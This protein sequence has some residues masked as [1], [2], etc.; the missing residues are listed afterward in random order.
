MYKATG[1]A[2]SRNW[3]LGLI[4]AI[5]LIPVS[6][7]AQN[8]RTVTGTVVDETG[9]PLIGASVRVV[10][11]STGV[12]TDI[13][14]R[15]S[16][17]VPASA[18]QLLF[19]YVGYHNLTAGITSDVVDV[20]LH[21]DNE[22]LD[23]VV[24]IGYGTQKKNDLT[25]SVSSVGEKDFNQGLISSPEELINGKIAGVQITSNGGS[26]NGGSTIRIR[27]GASLNAS[28]DPLIVLD[29]VPME[30]GDGITGSGN[31]LSMINPNDIESM[32][33]LKDASSTAIYG[34]RASNG[35]I[36]INTKKGS[37][38]GIKVSFQ[39][40]NSL[41]NATR[42]NKMLSRSQL[43]EEVYA[44][45]NQDYISALGDADTDWND[46]IFRT[47]FSTDNN[48][49]LSGRFTNW[50]PFRVSLGATY[51]E[52]ILKNDNSQ[53]YTANINLTPSFFGD[54]LR[55][56]LSG[57]GSYSKNR[58]ANSGAIWNALAYDPTQ[59]VYGNFD[60]DGNPLLFT[61]GSPLMGGFHQVIDK[62][63]YPGQGAIA[64]P[65]AMLEDPDNP[66]DVYRIVSNLDVEYRLHF[67][68]E[69][70]L[71]AT[72]GVDWARGTSKYYLP[73]NSFEGFRDGGS[74]NEQG[75]QINL[76]QVLTLY[77]NYNKDFEA[78]KSTVDVTA[79]YDYQYWK[80][81]APGYDTFNAAGEYRSTSA[82]WDERHSLIS[83]Y[84]RINY[85]LMN[86]YLLTATMRRDGS[87]RFSKENRW[88]SFPS[89]ALAWRVSQEN[90]FEPLTP[91]VNDL[92]LRASYGITGQ[93]DGIANYSHI[94]NYTYSHPGAS[95]YYRGEWI[96]TVRPSAYNSDL[97]WETT[98]S[99]NFGID[100]AFLSNRLTASVDYYTRKTKDLLATVP[101]PAGVNFAKEMLTNVGNVDSKGLEIALTAHIIDTRDFGWDA[102][103]NA[104]WL[105]NKITNLSLNGSSDVSDTYVGYAESTPV[106]VYKPG[107]TPHTFWLYKQIYAADGT[108]VEGLYAD[109]NGDG[110]VDSNDKYYC[111]SSHP[112]WMFGLT[113]SFRWRKLTLSTSLRAQVGNYLYDQM[114]A[115]MGAAECFSW[116][117]GQ[118]NNLSASYADTHFQRRRYESDYYL[119]NASF[120]K[121]D[122]LQL[123]YD[124]G[125]VSVIDGLHVSA[126]VQNVFT[127]TK[128]KGLDPESDWG[129]AGSAYPRPRT[130][131]LT[132]G[133]NF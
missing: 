64:N 25:G 66:A 24:V 5:L 84:G 131:S 70:R 47:A 93:Q 33:I 8:P 3:W 78:I 15:Y 98:K 130:Y 79:G 52:G 123:T 12:A 32:T 10:G 124:F 13:D 71:H 105:D 127:I 122:N 115:G 29:G 100:L 74:M 22:I 20:T 117:S 116:C 30:K 67:L 59:P 99:W 2:G 34:S 86:R 18:K 21:P 49:A 58:F 28:N 7:Y 63:G 53:R 57:K 55:I 91:V 27:G 128:Y 41:S 56:N 83:Y 16:L 60:A 88:G 107:Y 68:P 126:M 125:K 26:P 133:L 76:N 81:S 61:D 19:S 89:V 94:S 69:L 103:F 75:P 108:P 62:N 54:K 44:T 6:A 106:M 9:E 132:V 97:K 46:A 85:T 119:Q 38:S 118:V 104:T 112:D 121:M 109:L 110:T 11:E 113:T 45:G 114:S 73:A 129:V 35:V 95:Y 40:T 4:L 39:T 80:R 92:K 90:F 31:F 111:H 120:L 96:Q 17:K 87:S 72:G 82:P 14:G 1:Y 48:L 36:I 102:T 51:Q 65:L 43:V 42:H 77:A 37:G 23:E 50:L 101:V